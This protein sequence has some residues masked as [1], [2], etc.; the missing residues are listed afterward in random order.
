MTPDFIVIHV[1]Q[2]KIMIIEHIDLLKAAPSRPEGN[3]RKQVN[4]IP[5]LRRG[6]LTTVVADAAI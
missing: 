2:L 4:A 1:V 5:S 3:V 6:R